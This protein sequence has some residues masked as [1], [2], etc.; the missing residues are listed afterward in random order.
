MKVELAGQSESEYSS[1]TRKYLEIEWMDKPKMEI[2]VVL[3]A[4]GS[5]QNNSKMEQAKLAAKFVAGGF[6]S[7]DEKYDASNVRV[8]VYSFNTKK[9]TAIKVCLIAVFTFLLQLISALLSCICRHI[10]TV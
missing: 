5:M 1:V 4:S 10:L 7:D 2:A 6:L 3:D 9:N 8:A